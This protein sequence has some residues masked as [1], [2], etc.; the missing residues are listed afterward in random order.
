M[1]IEMRIKMAN[2]AIAKAGISKEVETKAA[3]KAKA[4]A[5][6]NKQ[7]E[8]QAEAQ[9]E[10]KAIEELKQELAY[11]KYKAIENFFD[12]L[13]GA[14]RLYWHCLKKWNNYGDSINPQQADKED[15]TSEIYTAILNYEQQEDDELIE[16]ENLVKYWGIT[17]WNQYRKARNAFTRLLRKNKQQAFTPEF[18]QDFGQQGTHNPIEEAEAEIFFKAVLTEKIYMTVDLTDRGYT[19]IEIA[20]VMGISKMTVRRNQAKAREILAAVYGYEV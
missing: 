4:K 17:S 2:E 15:L 10:Q 20:Q 14:T 13:E 8:Q 1:T 5:G 9:A 6:A 11:G 18:D 12:N 3:T 7:A 16:D 19:Q